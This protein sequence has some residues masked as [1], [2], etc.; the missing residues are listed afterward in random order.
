MNRIMDRA[1]KLKEW[2]LDA[3]GAGVCAALAGAWYLVGYSPLAEARAQRE[4]LQASV[5]EQRET[6]SHLVKVQ[7]G[8]EH[9]RQEIGEKIE[10]LN[11]HLGP[12][13]ELLQRMSQLTA[14][15]KKAGLTLDET[16]PGV[17]S[18]HERFITVPIHMTGTGSYV[19]CTQFLHDLRE[20][21]RDT[22]VVGMAMQGEPA[23]SEKPARFTLELV[24][25]A[26]KVA[27]PSKT[28]QPEAKTT[29]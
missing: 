11:V 27:P 14:S 17:A 15:A 29:K 4:S 1:R 23:Q 24:W 26:A 8:Y 3:I 13:D 2:Q 18:P 7:R 21:F 16:K 10:K 19:Q 25:Y 20:H 6:A 12:A 9:S 5:D 22:G 28:A